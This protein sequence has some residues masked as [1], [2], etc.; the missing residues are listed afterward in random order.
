MTI[1]PF[2]LYMIL[3]L[4]DIRNL[5]SAFGAVFFISCI[6]SATLLAVWFLTS[7]DDLD[8]ISF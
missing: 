5:L 7:M 8:D 2:E 3:K 4:D 1:S 6:I